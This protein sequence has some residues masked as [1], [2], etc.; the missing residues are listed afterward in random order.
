MQSQ[1]GEHALVALV[2]GSTVEYSEGGV[3]IKASDVLSSVFEGGSCS[4]LEVCVGTSISEL[5]GISI[6]DEQ[7][8]TVKVGNSVKPSLHSVQQLQT[9]QSW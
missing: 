9:G 5:T 6:L 4:K 7:A 1:S 8:G 2:A 3:V